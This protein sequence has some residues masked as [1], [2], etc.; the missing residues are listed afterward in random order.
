MYTFELLIQCLEGIDHL[1]SKGYSHGDISPMSIGLVLTDPET[2][3]KDS[4][5]FYK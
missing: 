4:E 2:I 5:D 1:N 3:K